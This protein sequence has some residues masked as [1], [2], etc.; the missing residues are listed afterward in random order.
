MD[1]AM[2]CVGGAQERVQVCDTFLHRAG[3]RA[4]IGGKS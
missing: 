4:V 3:G 2:K 1:R